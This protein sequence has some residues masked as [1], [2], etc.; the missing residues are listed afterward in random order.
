M[1]KVFKTLDNGQ[2][3]LPEVVPVVYLLVRASGGAVD[4]SLRDNIQSINLKEKLISSLDEQGL[5]CDHQ[6]PR[7]IFIYFQE[8]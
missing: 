3:Q 7:I 4:K 8:L 5:C 1:K 6:E 2:S